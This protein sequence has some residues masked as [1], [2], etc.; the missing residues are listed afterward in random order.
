MLNVRIDQFI[1]PAGIEDKV[2]AKHGLLREEVEEAFFHQEAKSRRIGDR[3]MLLSR[4]AGGNYIVVI[5]EF[6]ARTVTVISARPMNNRE[7]RL[8][9]RK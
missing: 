2:R 4:S 3:Y 9:R 8:F 1:W 7:K 5:F 6:A